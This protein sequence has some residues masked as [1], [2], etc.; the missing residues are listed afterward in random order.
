[1]A[2]DIFD[3][4]KQD[5]DQHRELLAQIVRQRTASP[6]SSEQLFERFKVE[7]DGPRRGR[8]G[9]ALRHDAGARPELRHDARPFGRRA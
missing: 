3:R 6:S 8:G 9:D 2:Q 1:M 5:H 4:L 7:V